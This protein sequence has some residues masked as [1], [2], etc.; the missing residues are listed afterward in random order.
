MAIIDC[1]NH[2]GSNLLHQTMTT[3]ATY[4]MTETIVQ[5]GTGRFL[6]AFVDRFV[7]E[8]NVLGQNVGSIVVVQSTGTD[9][10]DQINAQKG[11]FHIAVRGLENGHIVRR[12]EVASVSRCLAAT[13]DWQELGSVFQSPELRFIISNTTEKGY[14]ISASDWADSEVPLSFPARLTKLLFVRFQIGLSGLT[15][16]PCELRDDQADELMNLVCRLAESWRY[17]RDFLTWVQE[18]CVWLN[19]LVDRIVVE[20]PGDHPLFGK[21]P[22]LVMAEPYALWA[23]QSKPR[24]FEFV[25]HPNIVRADDIRP[26]FLRKVRILNAAHTALVTKARRRGYETVLQAMEDHELSDWL[27]RLVMD[28]IVPTLQDRVEDAAGFAQA[29]FMRFRNPF[30]AHKVSDILK[31]HDAKVRIRLVPT[32]EEFRARFHRAPNRLNEVLRENGIE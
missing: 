18:E 24:A 21:D 31:N 32:R 6:R 17:P 14:D 27:E 10:V 1:S 30:L 15:L 3:M 26:Y 25:H 12:D 9:A 13:R 19:S 2:V 28:E 11:I 22:L 4:S 16:M 29:T 7:H 5:F 20:A 8:A 23:L